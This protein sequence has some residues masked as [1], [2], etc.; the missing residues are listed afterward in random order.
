MVWQFES[1]PQ[2]SCVSC[3]AF[4]HYH[5]NVPRPACQR[6]QDVEQRQVIHHPVA[7]ADTHICEQSR[8]RQLSWP[9]SRV[10]NAYVYVAEL[11]QQSLNDTEWLKECLGNKKTK[12]IVRTL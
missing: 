9:P 12:H 1:R 6:M 2:E 10:T 5:E 3:L 7:P 4:C 8:Q 11:L